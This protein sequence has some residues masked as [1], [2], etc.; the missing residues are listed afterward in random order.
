MS[1][2]PYGFDSRCICTSLTA[3]CR[4]TRI[5]LPTLTT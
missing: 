1:L 3:L 5:I 2:Q 4:E